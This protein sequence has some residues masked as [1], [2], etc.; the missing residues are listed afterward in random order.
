MDIF[1]NGDYYIWESKEG[2]KNCE[3]VEYYKNGD[4]M[5]EGGWK[6]GKHYGQGTYYKCSGDKYTGQ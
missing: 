5:Y 4:M 6:N 2:W 1:K 3:G